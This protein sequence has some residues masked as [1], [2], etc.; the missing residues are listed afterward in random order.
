[1]RSGVRTINKTAITMY[2]LKFLQHNF[3]FS[4]VL[5]VE[6][7]NDWVC[8]SEVFSTSKP[9]FSSRS[10]NFSIFSIKM[11]FT[12]SILV[13]RAALRSF[14]ILEDQYCWQIRVT[15]DFWGMILARCIQFQRTYGTRKFEKIGKI[16]SYNICI[17][18]NNLHE[19]L[20]VNCP[21]IK[22]C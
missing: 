15:K 7:A 1:M 20:K 8:I 2:N 14:D 4:S 22:K 12:P 10:I 16:I 13:A 3:L 18:Y 11:P 5:L 19:K 21:R 6:K 9:I 17:I